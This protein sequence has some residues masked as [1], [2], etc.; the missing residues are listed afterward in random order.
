MTS[1]AF[2]ALTFAWPAWGQ[3]RAG[4]MSTDSLSALLARGPVRVLDVRSDVFTYLRGHLP[5]AQFLHVETLRTMRHGV[6]AQLLDD[7]AYRAL[8]G[9]LALGTDVPVVVYSAGE[10][11]NIDA[12]YVAFLLL[13]YGH[14][15]VHVLDGGFAKWELEHRPIVQAYA[16]VRSGPWPA[17]RRRALPI[18]S[19]AELL[20]L[21]AAGDVLVVDARPGE[22]F[23]GEQGAQMR[24]GHIPGAVSHPWAGDL[25]RDGFG[26][27]WK[28]PDALRASYAAQGITPDRDIVVYC[29]STTEASHVWWA[30]RVL[31]GYPR[32]RIYAGAWTEWAGRP[33]LPVATGP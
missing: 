29:N 1:V 4:I 20:R 24:R 11:A 3:A 25:T 8:F 26:L 28:S 10:S 22:Q 9:R 5:Q 16:D 30:L 6:P 7:A 21:R 31:L 14:P 2:A 13:G 23:R 12:T 19:L 27:V 32:V 15:S 33:E 17:G 18:V